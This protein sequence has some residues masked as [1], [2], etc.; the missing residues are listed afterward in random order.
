MDAVSNFAI[1]AFKALLGIAFMAIVMMGS[2]KADS[3]GIKPKAEYVL[4]VDWDTGTDDDVDTWVRTPDG[5]IIMYSTPECGTVHLER[6]DLGEA[7]DII[8]I[9]GKEVKNPINEEITTFRSV[10][11][12]EFVVNLHYYRPDVKRV[13][14]GDMTVHAKV[15]LTK[16]NPVTEVVFTRE[17]LL[18]KPKDEVHVFRFT[19]AEDG[20]VANVRTDLPATLLNERLKTTAPGSLREEEE[21]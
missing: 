10:W 5:C 2:K 11:P 7:N 1:T 9:D 12:G 3:D 14:S 17:I 16:L 20:T 21:P 19:M 15:T 8:V 4:T 13:S 18:T 6:D